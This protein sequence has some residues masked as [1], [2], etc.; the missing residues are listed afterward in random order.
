MNK[1]NG[2]EYQDELA[3]NLYDMD[4]RD[5]DPATARWT[6]V[7]PVTHFSQSPYN[8]FDGNPVSIADPSGADGVQG[9]GYHAN[10]LSNSPFAAGHLAVSNT[11]A[12]SGNTGGAFNFGNTSG[13]GAF[14]FG[15]LNPGWSDG[16]MSPYLYSTD[17][18]TWVKGPEGEVVNGEITVYTGHWVS[19]T[20]APTQSEKAFAIGNGIVGNYLFALDKYSIANSTKTYNYGTRAI[21]AIALT[22]ANAARML[23]IAKGAQIVGNTLGIATGIYSLYNAEQ[24]EE[25]QAILTLKVIWTVQ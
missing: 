13:G 25:Q 10:S 7:D 20:S 3:L 18:R 2:K 15:N 8:A 21:S 1:Y 19:N 17:K 6:G 24:E 9:A 22:E 16:Y 11:G 5:Y 14:G 4:M 12:W 23:N